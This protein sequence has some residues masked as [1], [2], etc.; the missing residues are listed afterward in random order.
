MKITRVG[1]LQ[2]D[3]ADV[4]ALRNGTAPQTL[5][6]Y[7]TTDAALANR[8]NGVLGWASNVLQIGT[9]A[10]GTGSARPVRIIVGGTQRWD[11]GT[12]GHQSPVADATYNLGSAA[13]RVLAGH[14]SGFVAVGANPATGSGFRCGNNDGLTARN[15]ANTANRDLIYLDTSDRVSVGPNTALA[16]VVVG[17][18][19]AALVG[20]YATAPVAQRLGGVTITNNVTPGGTTNQLDDFTSLSVYATDAAA[21]RNNIYQL[22]RKVKLLADALRTNGLC[23]NADA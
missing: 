23:Q 15:A 16:S 11:Y 8:E 14:F 3:A 6:I 9:E 1:P 2:S 12:A 22:G 10:A 21:I 13:A 17:N 5:R 4:W 7:N 19:A 18:N 20:F